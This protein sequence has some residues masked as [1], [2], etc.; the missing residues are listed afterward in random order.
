MKVRRKEWPRDLGR[1]GLGVDGRYEKLIGLLL[2]P[3][4]A[5]RALRVAPFKVFNELPISM[6]S[7]RPMAQYGDQE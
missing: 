4:A 2:Q 5:L 1:V 7:K 3:I 6:S